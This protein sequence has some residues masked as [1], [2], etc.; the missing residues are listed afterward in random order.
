MSGHQL[1]DTSVDSQE[2]AGGRGAACAVWEVEFSSL[3]PHHWVIVPFPHGWSGRTSPAELTVL[4]KRQDSM[5][6][7]MPTQGHGLCREPTKIT[8][9]WRGRYRG[10]WVPEEGKRS[11]DDGW[12]LRCPPCQICHSMV[13]SRGPVMSRLARDSRGRFW[14][15]GQWAILRRDSD[16]VTSQSRTRSWSLRHLPYSCSL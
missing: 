1:T 6:S 8:S 7:W 9:E 16:R 4:G 10:W 5:R 12:R 3:W 13:A 14:M 2:G 15:L 11:E